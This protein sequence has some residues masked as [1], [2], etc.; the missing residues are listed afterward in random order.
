M[1][2]MKPA[3]NMLAADNETL[4]EKYLNKDEHIDINLD[5]YWTILD[6]TSQILLLLNPR[7]KLTV[8]KNLDKKIKAID[9]VSNLIGY[10]SLMPKP[11]TTFSDDLSNTQ[12]YFCQ[13]CLI[14]FQEKSNLDSSLLKINCIQDEV[15]DT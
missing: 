7:T 8:F 15:K 14:G 4:Y 13:L 1:E 10:S 6:E 11:T 2:K 9:L 5:S 12:N 3:L